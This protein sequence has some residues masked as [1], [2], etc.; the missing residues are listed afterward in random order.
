[1]NC[2]K[3]KM[4]TNLKM[5]LVK[6]QNGDF[7]CIFTSLDNSLKKIEMHFVRVRALWQLNNVPLYLIKSTASRQKCL[8][9]RLR[10]ILQV[11]V[12]RLWWWQ[13]WWWQQWCQNISIFLQKKKQKANKK[14]QTSKNHKGK[15]SKCP[16]FLY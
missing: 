1:M 15:K 5:I 3:W 14:I 12:S 6:L 10:P 8:L 4:Y 2:K 9:L 16:C 7:F 11:I 13:Q